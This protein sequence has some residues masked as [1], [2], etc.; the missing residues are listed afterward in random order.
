[1]ET[2]TQ[3]VLSLLLVFAT[4]VL[5]FAA[6]ILQ[7]RAGSRRKLRSIPAFE[8]IPNWGSQ[9]IE[10]DSPLH[11]AF[12]S[13]SI[14]EDNTTTA[15][16]N[17]E[18]FQRIIAN[19]SAGDSP[20]TL[21]TSA[22]TTIPLAS[23]TVAA[24]WTGADGAR[25]LHWYPQGK[26]ALGYA[27]GISAVIGEDA[28]AAHILAG[29]FGMELGLILDSAGCNRQGS[30]AVSDQL[31]GQAVAFAMADEALIGEELF[32]A[33]AYVAD[34]SRLP[35]A[36]I[37]MDI[38]RALLMILVAAAL[39]MGIAGQLPW[40]SWQLLALVALVA[41][42]LGVILWTLRRRRAEA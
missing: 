8:R 31:E 10:A 11:L 33:P 24:A 20:P 16:A 18:L 1:M 13:A 2:T 4:I 12:G 5:V 30:L 22:P 21:S 28:P 35:A 15:L 40:L 27:A 42:V 41:L 39:V 29:S 14:G 9:A 3:Q 37:V 26:R 34:A 6:R 25:N 32:I 36:A 17:A 7:A 38:W 19:N 23:A